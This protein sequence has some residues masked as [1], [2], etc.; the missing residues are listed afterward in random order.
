[1]MNTETTSV[2]I[3]GTL[4][5]A[6]LAGRGLRQLLPE[7]HLSADTKEAVKLAMGLVATMTALLL[8]LLVS[9]AKGSYD[10][11]R[12]EV[13]Q[14]S[15]KVVFLDRLLSGYGPEAANARALFRDSIEDMIRRI[16]PEGAH[17]PV[18]LTPNTQAGNAVYLAM[19][20]LSPQNDMQRSLRTQALSTGVDLAQLRTLL[21]AQAVA[22]IS[23]PLLIVVVC[24]LFVIFLSF[25][26][27]A[28]PNATATL[29]LLIAALS[30]SGA[31][32]LILELDRPFGGLVRISSEPMLNALSHL[33]K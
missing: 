3:F 31:L 29:S 8:G 23:T 27:V 26:L 11:V 16:W 25:A 4:A 1:M 22:S 9:S 15:A 5:G 20:Q 2:V 7:R 30:V 6:V 10:T 32:F 14:M 24:W 17:V 33:A 19:Q 28:P 13:I 12:S 21:A 18:D